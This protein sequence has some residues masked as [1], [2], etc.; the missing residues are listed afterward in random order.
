MKVLINASNLKEGGSIQVATSIIYEMMNDLQ[1]LEANDITLFISDEVFL[2]LDIKIICN[3][4]IVNWS[5]LYVFNL[6]YIEIFTSFNFVFNI[7]G[8][9]YYFFKN[10]NTY[11]GFAL[12]YL[13]EGKQSIKSKLRKRFFLK[14]ENLIIEHEWLLEDT[15]KIFPQNN[16]VVVNNSL[17]HVFYEEKLKSFNNDYYD[18]LKSDGYKFFYCITRNYQHKNLSKLISLIELLNEDGKYALI[19][20][21]RKEEIEDLNINKKYFLNLGEVKIHDVPPIIE[22]CN[23]FISLSD[24][25]CF[26]ISPIEALKMKKKLFLNNKIFYKRIIGDFASYIDS[27]DLISSKRVILDSIND[28]PIDASRFL[29][30][31]HPK[32]RWENIKKI[33]SSYE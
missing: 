10:K 30:K 8:P 7:F 13:F 21:L 19:L 28:N 2:N 17:N 18:N 11:T 9:H 33:I 32:I 15:K 25:E 5:P 20:T 27:N 1:F 4:E 23:F 31:F 22:K 16:I 14:A 29:V 6:K 12:P 24:K 3:Y 26:S